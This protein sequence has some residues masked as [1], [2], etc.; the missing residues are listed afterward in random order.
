MVIE[1]RKVLPFFPHLD[2][3]VENLVHKMERMVTN[4]KHKSLNVEKKLTMLLAICN[5]KTKRNL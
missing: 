2:L 3:K 4:F 5:I 1:E